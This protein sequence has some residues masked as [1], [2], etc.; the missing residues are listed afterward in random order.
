MIVLVCG[1]RHWGDRAAT[2]SILDSLTV[3]PDLVIQ[4]GAK[5]ADLL[6]K[7]WAKERGIHCAQVDALWS[8]HG[9]AAG[10]KRNEAMFLLK[11]D[12][13]VAFPGG[14]GTESMIRICQD[15]I[16]VWVPYG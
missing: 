4:G 12:F 9:K 3:K 8:S 7:Q 15:R 2:F 6:G 13:C 5:G 10:Y 11:P 14:R 16:P 1:G